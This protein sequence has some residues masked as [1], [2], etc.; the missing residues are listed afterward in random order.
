MSHCSKRS[1][2]SAETLI[3]SLHLFEVVPIVYVLE[4]DVVSKDETDLDFSMLRNGPNVVLLHWHNRLGLGLLLGR[5]LRDWFV[6][7]LRAIR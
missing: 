4:V 3:R 1:R 5:G 2:V 7:Y 6:E